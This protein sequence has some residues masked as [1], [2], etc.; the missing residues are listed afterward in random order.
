MREKTCLYAVRCGNIAA[1][2]TCALVPI[3]P[4]S[5]Y[6]KEDKFQMKKFK[7]IAACA[8]ALVCAAAMTVS[9]SAKLTVV[10]QDGYTRSSDKMF[11]VM[12]YSD[13]TKDKGEKSATNYGIDLT[14]IGTIEYTVTTDADFTGA[15]GG[16]IILSSTGTDSG[17]K[18]NWIAKEYWGVNDSD[19][20]LEAANKTIKFDKIADNTYK[21]VLVVDDSNCVYDDYYFVQLAINQYDGT[22]DVATV[23]SI[24][25]K[26]KN[27]KEM[28]SFD[29]KGKA[30]LPLLDTTEKVTSGKTEET[31][32]KEEK[33]AETTTE[34]AKEETK[35]TKKTTKEEEKAPEVAEED[36][37]EETTAADEEEEWVSTFDPSTV[38][39]DEDQAPYFDGLQ[40]CLRADNDAQ[41]SLEKDFG[42]DITQV[43]GIRVFVE[44]D[45][46]DV[47][48]GAWYGGS[49]G[50]NC[51]SR[52]WYQHNYANGD[53]DELTYDESEGSITFMDKEPIFSADDAY[54]FAFFQQWGTPI[55]PTKFEL[56]DKDGNALDLMGGAVSIEEPELIAPAPAASE[57]SAVSD[58]A[59]PNTGI[60]DV[61]AVAGIA[62]VAAGAVVLARKRK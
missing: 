50:A 49:V 19:R 37:E 10:P 5:N 47:E 13:G 51:Q 7:K 18:H 17:S 30:S 46:E 15:W 53:G 16:A 59:N 40:F 43:Y 21:G 36:V 2:P 14:K 34:K 12:L 42:F 44:V 61:A 45:P 58:N 26:D 23:K 29:G 8:A 57:V 38:A 27:G 3:A 28:I 25:V 6:F 52:G 9:A 4:M 39:F 22:P 56:L 60:E 54:A 55:A 41:A 62:A 48:H 31:T 11:L 35:K 20:G 32:A 33:P 24:V 1:V